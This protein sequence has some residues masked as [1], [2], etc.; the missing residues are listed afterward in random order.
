MKDNGITWRCYRD[1]S[2][3]PL[4]E[5]L[6]VLAR[7]YK[8]KMGVAPSAVGLPPRWKGSEVVELLGG[9]FEVFFVVPAWA[10]G[11]VWLGGAGK[12]DLAGERGAGG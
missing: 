8:E 11:E 2:G 3:R 4:V 10:G 9:R 7:L 5:K 6:A 1:G 12:D